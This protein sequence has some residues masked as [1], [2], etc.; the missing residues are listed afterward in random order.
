MIGKISR[1]KKLGI[2]VATL[3]LLAT[4]LTG[5]GN[6]GETSGGKPV[7]HVL[8]MYTSEDLNNHIIAKLLEERTGYKVEYETLPQDKPFDKLN[9]LLAS[10]ES[11][12]VVI[13][14]NTKNVYANYAGNGA[15]LDLT[16]LLEKYGSNVT[17]KI[18]QESFDKLKIDGKQYAIPNT[19]SAVI[20]NSIVVRTDW[21]EK[22][23]LE[24]PKTLDEFTEMLR[25]FKEKDPG[26]NGDQNVPFVMAAD[27]VWLSN[28]RGA[29]G[30]ATDWND[31]DGKL[32]ANVT[33]PE[34]KEYLS[35]LQQLY[36][37][38]LI[39]KEFATFKSANAKEK[40]TS[41]YAGAMTL[42]YFDFPTISD[43]LQKTVQGAS[44][45]YIPLLKGE[46]GTC[47]ISS[48]S[49][50]IDK[51]IFIP[52]SSKHPEDAM[53]WINAKLDD[54]LFKEFTIGIEGVHYE[55]KDGAYYPILPIFF[56]ERNAASVYLT[57]VDEEKYPLYWQTRVRKDEELFNAWNYLNSDSE[58]VANRVS[59]PIDSAPYIPAYDNEKEALDQD[60]RD[61]MTTVIAGDDDV[62]TSVDDYVGKWYE[63]GGRAME[64]AVNEWYTSVGK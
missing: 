11:Y 21:L 23:G 59:S 6:E 46:D 1:I 12:D 51:I 20:N 13:M 58:Y 18:S 54:D 5:C 29:F 50:G 64:E 9:L 44:F 2:G 3:A 62:S 61:F 38:G 25:Q 14:N 55:E 35:Y 19:A 32:T 56:D 34:F 45:E 63:A 33:R 43:T 47:G 24:M 48:N 37:E 7:L 42:A 40:F 39:D 28:V 15:L 36:S 27:D 17:S 41:G 10:G 49:T 16:D 57:G 4:G 52:K 53:K 31:L 8:Q 22:L 26:N 60:V 30:L